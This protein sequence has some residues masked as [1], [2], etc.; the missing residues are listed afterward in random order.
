MLY[1]TQ[2][3][4]KIEDRLGSIAYVDIVRVPVH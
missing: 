4:L 1:E 2:S 3:I